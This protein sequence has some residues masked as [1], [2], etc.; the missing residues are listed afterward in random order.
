[1]LLLARV[2]ERPDRNGVV[3]RRGLHRDAGVTERIRGPG[4]L[5]AGDRDV[6]DMGVSV[7]A[8]CA[9]GEARDGRLAGLPDDDVVA[10]ALRHADDERDRPAVGREGS[11]GR[12]G[13]EGVRVEH[14]LRRRERSGRRQR[15]RKR[16][17]ADEA[18]GTLAR[19]AAEALP[20]AAD[21][22]DLVVRLEEQ[23]PPVR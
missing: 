2:A 19:Q 20:V 8:R 18:V 14:A 1:V 10:V 17:P 13:R 23:L 15:G 5:G 4:N 12:R 11:D 3:E 7:A 6:V 22:P 9:Q 21:G 16:R